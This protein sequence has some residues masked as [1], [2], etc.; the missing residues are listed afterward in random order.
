MHRLKKLGGLAGIVGLA[1]S[2]LA[3][4][5]VDA[6]PSS[7]SSTSSYIVQVDPAAGPV[8]DVVAHAVA[9][10]GGSVGQVFTRAINGA[11][12]TLPVPAL[13]AL[14]AAPGMLDVSPNG[15]MRINQA[16]PPW[17]L[18]RIDQREPAAEQQLHLHQPRRRRHRLHHRHRH[19]HHP[20]RLRRPGLVRLRRHR[21]RRRADDCNG[22]GTHVAGTVGGAHL[23]RGQERQARRRPGARLQRQRHQ[24]AGDRRHRLGHR[25]PR[26]GK[27]AVANMSLGGGADTAHRHRDHATSINDGVTYVRRGR[28]RQRRRLQPLPGRGSPRPSPS[29]PPTTTTPWRRS[30]TAA[31]AST[32]SRPASN[33][34]VG[35]EHQRHRHQ[36]HQRHV[37]GHPAR[38]RRRGPRACRP[39]PGASPA[40]V[41]NALT[42]GATPDKITG[43]A[44]KCT[45]LF[46]GCRPATANNRLLFL[47]PTD[48][49]RLPSSRP[50]GRRSMATGQV[51]VDEP[52]R[53]HER[54]DGGGAHEPHPPLAQRLRQR[55][56]LR[57]S[58]RGSRSI[59]ERSLAGG[60]RVRPDDLL[61]ATSPRR[62]WPAPPARWRSCAVILPR[63]R[64]MPA[65]ASSR[66][67]SLSE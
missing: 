2:V 60:G 57:R 64:T 5:P 67:T 53:L 27:P 49:S 66:S 38:R 44:R 65:L 36:H 56:R 21:R 15:T 6:R 28:Q 51:I 24:R 22:H 50:Q 3:I 19:P 1:L 43:T 30:P 52:G 8:A 17:G 34:T 4:A 40:A 37:D 48:L 35:L 13:A 62:A 63:W 23:R 11:V 26:A 55:R 32:S 45:L 20:R 31:P 14:R 42:S 54:V 29:A 61:R 9:P 10:L 33:I 16:N 18:D 41:A 58:R 25:Q 7:A 12:V 47:D 39:T 59:T 46:V